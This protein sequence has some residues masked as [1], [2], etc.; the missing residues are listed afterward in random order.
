MEWIGDLERF[1]AAAAYPN[2]LVIGLVGVGLVL[3][4]AAAAVR[5]RWDLAARRHPRKTLAFVVPALVVVLPLGWYL[6]SP[7]VLSSTLDEPAPVVVAARPSGAS[8]SRSSEASPRASG[9][10]TQPPDTVTPVPSTPPAEPIKR[11]GAFHG[12]DEFHFGRGAARLIEQAPGVFVVRLEGFEVRNGPDLYVYLSPEPDAYA[13]GAV[14]LGKLKADKGN[15][16]YEVP[17]GVDPRSATSV[18]IWCRQF[19]VLFA[20]ARLAD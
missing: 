20:W 16:N 8:A 9:A 14:E 6:G 18:V 4:L 15:Q 7:L 11:A 5:R 10:A 2:R 12:A 3:V 19:S 13:A 17:P 1:L